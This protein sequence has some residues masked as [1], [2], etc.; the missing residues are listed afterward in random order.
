MILASCRAHQDRIRV[1]SGWLLQ[2][3]DGSQVILFLYFKFD[4]IS[5]FL[6]GMV[7]LDITILRR[8]LVKVP[9]GYPLEKAGP[10]FCA[11]K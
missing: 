11:G 1:H 9:E 4:V 7:S 5:G 2:I 3:N 6:V 8:Y 10:I